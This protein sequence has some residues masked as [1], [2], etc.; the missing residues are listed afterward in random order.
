MGACGIFVYTETDGWRRPVSKKE[1]KSTIPERITVEGT[2]LL[3][4]LQGS[5]LA[6]KLPVGRYDF[7]GPDPY[8]ARDFFGNLIVAEN[9]QIYVK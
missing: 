2:S 7:V 6:T 9:G 1:V 4:G 3:G 5:H 8:S